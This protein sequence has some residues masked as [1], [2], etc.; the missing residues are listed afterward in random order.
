MPADRDLSAIRADAAR[1]Q[2]RL[3]A[4]SSWLTTT[5]LA[6]RWKC[7]DTTIR[8]I[9]VTDLP[10]LT[11]GTGLKKPHRRYARAD[12]ERYERRRYAGLTRQELRALGVQA[13]DAA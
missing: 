13:E 1:E 4:E 2:Q 3:D 9:P 10:Y 11:I 6:T 7:S 12:V 8:D 5:E